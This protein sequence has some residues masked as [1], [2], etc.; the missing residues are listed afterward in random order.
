MDSKFQIILKN[1]YKMP[2]IHINPSSDD[3]IFIH[4]LSNIGNRIE[5]LYISFDLSITHSFQ[6]KENDIASFAIGRRPVSNL[7]IDD[8]IIISYL[9]ANLTN[10]P[11][12]LCHIYCFFQLIYVLLYWAPDR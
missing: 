8:T 9:L 4:I 12:I 1:V 5:L 11:G 7:D 3:S 6:G 2:L 10:I